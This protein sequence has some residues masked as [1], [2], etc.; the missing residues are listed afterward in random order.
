MFDCDKEVL[1]TEEEL[2]SLCREWQETLRLEDW[3]VA[4]RVTRRNG[5]SIQEGSLMGECNILLDTKQALINI[6][7]Q[8]DYPET[9]FLRDMECDLVHELV[10][11]HFHSCCY[12]LDKDSLEHTMM[13]VAVHSIALALVKAKRMYK[14]QGC[15]IIDNTYQ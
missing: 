3:D 11:L 14:E 12:A 13:E 4:L 5:F 1:L 8:R 7:D 2:M 9:P 10:H 15:G 6:L